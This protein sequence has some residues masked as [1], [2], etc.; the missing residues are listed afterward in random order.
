MDDPYDDEDERSAE[1]K[2]A[3]LSHSRH[4]VSCAACS[5]ALPR[6]VDHYSETLVLIKGAGVVHQKPAFDFGAK[7]AV[8]AALN[9]DKPVIINC[10]FSAQK[11]TAAYLR[12]LVEAITR[13]QATVTRGLHFRFFPYISSPLQVSAMAS[14]AK[15]TGCACAASR[16]CAH[17]GA[18]ARAEQS[19]AGARRQ[20]DC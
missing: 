14:C 18:D 11:V 6:A 15:L 4:H 8:P 9:S 19:A 7:K 5:F 1:I 2:C 12:T 10:P 20:S 3:F 13:A 16:V 17:A